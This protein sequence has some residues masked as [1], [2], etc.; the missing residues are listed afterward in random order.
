[1]SRP[2]TALT[3]PAPEAEWISITEAQVLAKCSQP[4]VAAAIAA[5]EII[6]RRG[7]PRGV[8]SLH[9]ESAKEWARRWRDGRDA[10]AAAVDPKPESSS[11]PPDAEHTWLDTKTAALTIGVSPT[12][13]VTLAAQDRAPH[14]HVGRRLWWRRDHV[15]IMAAARGLRLRGQA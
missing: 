9:H 2:H 14:T 10:R 11:A 8:P 15:E 13:L 6:Q 3:G 5:G 12:W 4:T 1:M 7:L